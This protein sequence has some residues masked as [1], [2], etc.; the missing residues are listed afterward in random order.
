MPGKRSP[1][2]PR[3]VL[4][5]VTRR[6]IVEWLAL[7]AA[8]AG[9]AMLLGRLS[10]PAPWLIAPILVGIA[11]S[12]G[13][14]VDLR[15]PRGVFL[16]AQAAIGMLIAQTF[17]PPVAASIARSWAVMALVVATTILAAAI[18]GWILAKFSSIPAATAAWGSAPGGAAAM[19][20]MS[21]DYG[22]DPR[23]VAFMQYLRVTLVVLS[24]AA[25]SRILL[26]P[27]THVHPPGATSLDPLGLTETAAAAAVG[28]WGATKLRLPAG[29]LLGPLFVGGVLEGTGV[30]RIAV[31]PVALDAAYLAV[32]LAIGLLYTR[33]TVRYA[34]RVLPQL[35]A[36]TVVLIA[37]C[38]ASAATL[39]ATVH[40]DALTAYLA[41]TPG[42]LDSVTAIAL[43]SG[44]NVP[45]V[46]AVQTFR[47]VV[48]VITGPSLAKLIARAAA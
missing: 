45:L 32:G 1:A 40:V 2:A 39:V 4:A 14:L 19:T 23:I 48:V 7:L 9:A 42:G 16:A 8:G 33:E 27:G 30:A 34:L 44:A 47:M 36:S 10:V 20:A 31:P 28:V 21:I 5:L 38:V 15:M 18:A 26:P 25:V 41:T 17:T 11:A 35:V 29:A 46:L 6:T 13:G 37:L 43:G 22:A 3:R 24:A 12:A